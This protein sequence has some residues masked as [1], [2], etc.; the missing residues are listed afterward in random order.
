MSAY[1]LPREDDNNSPF[2][3]YQPHSLNYRN[4]HAPQG[5]A[6][7]QPGLL[8][9]KPKG[10]CTSIGSAIT[11]VWNQRQKLEFSRAW[12]DKIQKSVNAYG[13]YFRNM[14][15]KDTPKIMKF[16]EERY[17]PLQQREISPFDLFRWR[18]FGHGLLLFNRE[19]EV[20]GTVFEI[21]YRT[22]EKTSFTIR[23]AVAE[24]LSGKNL[25]YQVMM[26]SCLLAMER[27]SRVKRGIIQ[28]LNHRSLYINLNRVG[29][30]CDGFESDLTDLGTFYHISLPLDPLS[31]ISNQ[32]DVNKAQ[33]YMKKKK[34]GLHYELIPADNLD[35]ARDL[36]HHTSFKIAGFLKA[37]IAGPEAMLL[38][39]SSN[40]LNYQGGDQDWLVH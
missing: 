39:I 21:S 36:F 24:E 12:R 35:M 30:I 1:Q 13:L 16:M 22:E 23:L 7:P 19:G 4:L 8:F 37:G 5:H 15:D 27:G 11:D 32:I 38:A 31:L 40:E 26:Y 33:V 17:P 14:D 2:L 9:Q 10:I 18:K 28:C 6:S 20:K 3:S 29:W 25:G 34:Q